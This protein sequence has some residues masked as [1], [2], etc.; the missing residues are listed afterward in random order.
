[1]SSGIAIVIASHAGLS[2]SD[3][4]GGRWVGRTVTQKRLERGVF[5]FPVDPSR[6][7]GDG[8]RV[9]VEAAER[10][11]VLEGIELA[12][13]KR[14]KRFTPEAQTMPTVSEARG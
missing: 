7:G 10:A 4:E 8:A 9:E 1:L 2:G 14:R 11:L 3:A 12:G 6:G 13:A 5:R